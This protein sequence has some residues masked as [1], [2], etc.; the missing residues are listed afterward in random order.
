MDAG[1][2]LACMAYVDL[3][4]VWAQI[5]DELE[6]CSLSCFDFLILQRFQLPT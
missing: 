3:N 6:E 4:P 5:A 2:M 1:A